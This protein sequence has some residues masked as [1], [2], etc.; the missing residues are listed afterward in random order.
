[1]LY[2]DLSIP[3]EVVVFLLKIEVWDKYFNNGDM[4]HF[5]TV[6]L[7]KTKA[8]KPKIERVTQDV[9]SMNSNDTYKIKSEDI[10][11][12]TIRNSDFKLS[13]VSQPT[14]LTRI[15]YN[16]DYC[17]YISVESSNIKVPYKIC[18]P[19]KQINFIDIIGN[20]GY[21][22]N[23]NIHGSFYYMN[24][25]N[26][27][28]SRPEN[29]NLQENLFRINTLHQDKK[30]T[31][32]VPGHKYLLKNKT[33]I[34]YLGEFKESRY[35]TDSSWINEVEHQLFSTRFS[36]TSYQKT[37]SKEL[38][39][40]L[41]LIGR[42]ACI[43]NDSSF[44]D[45]I[46]LQENSPISEF[47]TKWLEFYKDSDDLLRCISFS[48]SSLSGVD[49]GKF[50]EQ[51]DMS[52]DSVIKSTC[53]LE[54]RNLLLDKSK[55]KDNRDKIIQYAQGLGFSILELSDSEKDVLG[56][57]IVKPELEKMF[58]NNLYRVR[59]DVRDKIKLENT[60]AINIYNHMKYLGTYYIDILDQLFNKKESLCGL[61]YSGRD[62][63][64]NTLI[65]ETKKV[66][67]K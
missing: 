58:S 31:I 23:N 40:N 32:L 24:D 33:K 59:S 9:I 57:L 48:D 49:L 56:E 66:H 5:C 10:E 28:Q 55:L 21:I 19:V 22:T 8:T 6:I 53:L 45:F 7:D 15:Y 29:E 36:S 38:F 2:S 25:Q 4:E 51:D 47:I 42:L 46:K 3:Y 27:C 30:T 34:L 26:F 41:D 12:V 62:T 16:S 67:F 60:S 63:K 39:I 61:L 64:L 14:I 18:A 13:V 52:I 44:L 17:V 54:L 43:R 37:I 20:C 35:R 65:I 50:L 1:M 11:V